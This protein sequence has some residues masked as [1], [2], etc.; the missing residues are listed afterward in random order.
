MM[1]Y[2]NVAILLLLLSTVIPLIADWLNV[3]HL[4]KDVHPEFIEWYD[5]E[6]YGKAQEYLKVQTLFSTIQS[7][8]SFI[9]VVLFISFKGFS[10]VENLITSLTDIYWIKSALFVGIIICISSIASIPFSLYHTFV[11]EEKF[12]F[13][14]TT[15]AVFWGDF[16]KSLFLSILL[17][18]PL[19]IGLI[20]L[21]GSLGELAWIV[22]WI[23]LFLIQ[24]L[25][26]FLAPALIMPL[27]NTFTPLEEGSLKGKIEEYA[28]NVGF[29]FGGISVMDGSKRSQKANAFF[30]GF[31]KLRKIAL[32]DT[33]IEK[34]SDDELVAILAHE[35][36]HFKKMHIWQMVIFSLISTG[37]LFFLMGKMQNSSAMYQAF[38]FTDTTLYALPLLFSFFMMPLNFI[39][40]LLQMA[41]SRKNEFE[42]DAF[43]KETSSAEHLITGLKRLSV[44]SLSN[45]E[46]HWF[47][48]F[49]EYSHP[50]VLKRIEALRKEVK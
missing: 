20:G 11:I 5:A 28:K 18:V 39:F 10:L 43:A 38:G 14:R 15:K 13:N 24:L 29:R 37:I 32:F 26:M 21:L 4:P 30:T 50:P 45:L 42:A 19:Y 7:L 36:G 3:K 48:V 2:D 1:T 25:F 34:H 40:G 35:V 27:F 6:K 23:L 31:G 41:L 12:G 47:K 46:P 17:G 49:L 16:I 8:F 9:C 33:L 44:D 22:A